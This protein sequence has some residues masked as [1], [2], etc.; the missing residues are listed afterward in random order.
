MPLTEAS[1]SPDESR[2]LTV[3]DNST[4]LQTDDRSHG[5]Y[6]TVTAGNEQLTTTGEISS[7]FF[8]WNVLTSDLYIKEPG[9]VYVCC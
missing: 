4:S 1:S 6:N 2:T 3:E 5:D 9:L 8:Y 7:Q